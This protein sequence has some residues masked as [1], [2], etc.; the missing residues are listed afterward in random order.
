MILFSVTEV[1]SQL[2]TITI[3]LV[4]KISINDTSDSQ[5]LS[6]KRQANGVV[7]N[8]SIYQDISRFLFDNLPEFLQVDLFAKKN[9]STIDHQKV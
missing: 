4:K 3:E 7:S 8:K 5:Y 6:Q 9:N 2:R 1:T